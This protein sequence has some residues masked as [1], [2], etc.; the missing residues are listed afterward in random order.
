MKL[1]MSTLQ[2][3]ISVALTAVVFLFV[4]VQ[5]TLAYLSV[6][7]QEDELVNDI[8]MSEARRLAK[9]IGNAEEPTLVADRAMRLSSDMIAWLIPAGEAPL[10]VPVWLQARP[11]GVHIEHLDTQVMHAVI[12]DTPAGRLYVEYDATDNEAFVYAFGGFL[13]L[14]GI[15]FVLL[16]GLLSVW[17]ARIVVAPIGRLARQLSEWSPSRSSLTTGTSDEETQLLQAFDQAQRRMDQAL[18]HEREFA[19]NVRHEVRT[20]LSALRTD[21]ELILLTAPALGSDARVRL[22]RIISAADAVAG[23]VVG[24]GQPVGGPADF[25]DARRGVDDRIAQ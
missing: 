10:I 14:T 6:V 18:A 9:R 17:I 19:A 2:W 1:R 22:S 11:P 20:P 16:G 5:G 21:A 4:T 7:H 12:E 25:A 23:A 3:R 13:L 8:V 15:A 24:D